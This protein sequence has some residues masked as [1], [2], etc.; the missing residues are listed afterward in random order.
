[1]RNGNVKGQPA[2]HPLFRLHHALFGRPVSVIQGGW[3]GI[4]LQ[5]YLFLLLVLFRSLFVRAAAA[6]VDAD[7]GI[8]LA[9]VLLVLIS[10]M[11]AK[12]MTSRSLRGSSSRLQAKKRQTATTYFQSSSSSSC[13]DATAAPSPAVVLD[14]CPYRCVIAMQ[15]DGSRE[16]RL[17]VELEY[18]RS[19]QQGRD[20][21]AKEGVV[22]VVLGL[23]IVRNDVSIILLLLVLRM[24]N[25]AGPGFWILLMRTIQMRRKRRAK[26]RT[27]RQAI[28]HKATIIVDGAHCSS[29]LPPSVCRMP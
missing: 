18:L 25:G 5:Y 12:L 17:Q 8:L 14:A 15:Q 1:M 11:C 21:R 2:Q 9:D 26:G 19:H 10:I 22:V 4:P 28:V 13:S 7:D 23:D 24:K 3:S 20:E 27:Q 16:A 6:A 29:C